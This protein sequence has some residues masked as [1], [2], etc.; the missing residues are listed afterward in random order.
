[1]A[2]HLDRKPAVHGEPRCPVLVAGGLAGR[3]PAATG[4]LHLAEPAGAPEARPAAG[5]RVD[6]AEP[7]RAREPPDADRDPVGPRRARDAAHDLTRRRPARGARP[8]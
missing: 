2:A 1:D 8:A 5:E 4:L 6:A 7:A 3:D